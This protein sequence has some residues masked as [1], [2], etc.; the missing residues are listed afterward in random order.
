MATTQRDYYEVLGVERSAD[1]AELKR[2]Y[3]KLAMEYHPDRN[4]A[5]GAAE[6]FK[7]INQA[8]EILTDD[9]KRAAYDRF[10]H[11][12][13]EGN[14][15]PGGFDGF[16]HFDGFG[17]IFDA[18]FGGGQRGSRGGRRRGP[19]RGAD[20]RYN[21]RLTFEEAVFGTE[22]EIEFQRQERCARCAGKGA[23][24]GTELATCPECNGAG[25]IRRSQQSIFGQF[26]NVA[27]CARCQGE[28]RIVPNPCE[29]CRGTGRIRESR[30]IAVKVPA[31]VDN[32]AQ[33][34]ISNEGE[35][36]ARGGEQGNLYVVLA[37]AD[38]ERFQRVEDHIVL[39]LPVNIAQAT[40][41]AELSIPTIDGEMDLEIPAGTQ[42]GEDFVIRGKGVP[43]LRG[44]G[45]GDMVVRVTV[46]V[47]ESLT[48][49]QRG[50][51][52][53][54]AATMGTPTLPKQNRGFFE[55]IR[56]AMAG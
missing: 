42:S 16:T 12:G 45:R 26:V 19:A 37:V 47:P 24:P 34:R 31:G 4:Q 49:E 30:K 15:G 22:K 10:G 18:F 51:L 35:A 1:A 23:E 38:H 11:A 28:G 29:D 3:R 40:L 5:D 21:L 43:H 32:G 54:L 53:Q 2:A 6:K 41:G 48:D 36:G 8:Y 55:R 44:A 50:L 52:E 7:E 14:G 25:E 33:I 46:V 56:D 20:L 27:A 39:E 13:V 17:D 9:Q